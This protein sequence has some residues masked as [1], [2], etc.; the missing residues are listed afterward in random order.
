MWWCV[1]VFM[2]A[3]LGFWIRSGMWWW[4]VYGLGAYFGMF[5]SPSVVP[6]AL[7]VGTFTGFCAGSARGFVMGI[8]G[9]SF[10]LISGVTGATSLL[11]NHFYLHCGL[12]K[13]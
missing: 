7:T 2:N 11:F 4:G 10:G 9:F 8:V 3:L 12:T 6:F 13:E 1:F 5:L